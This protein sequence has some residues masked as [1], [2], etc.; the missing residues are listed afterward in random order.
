[1]ATMLHLAVSMLIILLLSHD[2][3]FDDHIL[4][5]VGDDLVVKCSWV[6]LIFIINFLNVF[7]FYLIYVLSQ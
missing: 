6:V 2:V 4:F 1:V 7:L 3:A 5:V